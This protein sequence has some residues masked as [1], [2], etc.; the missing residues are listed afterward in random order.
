MS[1]I[2]A[3]IDGI[4]I[5]QLRLHQ[6]TTAD[7]IHHIKKKLQKKYPDAD[8]NVNGIG[9]R[10]EILKDKGA[11]T[12]QPIKQHN[13]FSDRIIWKLCEPDS[14]PNKVWH[15]LTH[16]AALEYHIQKIKF[17]ITKEYPSITPDDVSIAIGK[18]VSKEILR[19][20]NNIVKVTPSEKQFIVQEMEP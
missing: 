9:C 15:M 10:L 8:F 20:Q 3:D 4:I 1:R 16:I 14:T 13:P 6:T 18:L 7:L 11:I 12:D 19:I 2:A 17:T 5:Y